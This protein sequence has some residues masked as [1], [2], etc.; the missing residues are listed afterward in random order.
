V[1]VH[2]EEGMVSAT[3]QVALAPAEAFRVFTAEIGS[4]YLVDRHTVADHERTVDIRI[5][6]FAGGRLMDVYDA[7]TGEGREMG[8]ITEWEAGHRFAFTDAR[9]TRTEVH[10][11]PAARGT[12][13][14]IEQRGLDRLPS[15]EA[16]HVRRY[17]WH[18]LLDWFATASDIPHEE[19]TVTDTTDTTDKAGSGVTIQGLTPYLYY[20]DA[21]AALDW[22]ARVFGFIE[23]VRYVDEA[24]VV[25]ESEMRVG[26]A[27]IQLCG[28][29]P[30]PGHGEGLLTIVHVDDV[31]A[32]HAR[33]VAAGV[34]APAPE[35]QPY[36]PRTFTVTDPW[37]YNWDFWQR[38]HDY[39]EGPGGLRE[40]RS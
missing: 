27:T 26:S 19:A 13:V 21:G 16:E 24:G 20:E 34:D 8:R 11:E 2:A 9:D 17:G 3:V 37:G 10:F 29:A 36:G 25:K 28:H 12:A 33:V 1:S 38:V 5:E 18:L 30:D 14:T 4:W 7:V 39:V 31:D 40:V 23:T 15:G 6:P 32:Q 35:Q 22:L